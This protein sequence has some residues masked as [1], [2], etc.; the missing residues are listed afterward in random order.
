MDKQAEL[1]QLMGK[2]LTAIQTPI[3][4]SYN[5][6]ELLQQ[7]IHKDELDLQQVNGDLDK[8][9]VNLHRVLIYLEDLTTEYE[10]VKSQAI[11]DM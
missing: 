4:H 10:L 5:Y 9:M 6:A 2:M 7:E 8:I 11:D 1:I 3:A